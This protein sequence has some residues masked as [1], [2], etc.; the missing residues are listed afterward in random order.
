MTSYVHTETEDSSSEKIQSEGCS[1]R[2]HTNSVFQVISSST[3]YLTYK[4]QS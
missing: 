4:F 1:T 2:F 3:F